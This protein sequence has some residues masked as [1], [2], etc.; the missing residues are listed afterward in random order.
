MAAHED[1][2]CVFLTYQ[3]CDFNEDRV[4]LALP[5][6]EGFVLLFTDFLAGA[7]EKF[8]VIKKSPDEIQKVRVDEE[9]PGKKGKVKKGEKKK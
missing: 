7:H 2:W 8:Q 1:E 5:G 9:T 3:F 4:G 6:E